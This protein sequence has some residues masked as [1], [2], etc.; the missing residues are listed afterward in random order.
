MC[1]GEALYVHGAGKGRC[2][3]HE[4]LSDA[5]QFVAWLAGNDDAET[6]P[7]SERG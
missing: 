5:K 6:L 3:G 1:R 2:A 4:C 7:A